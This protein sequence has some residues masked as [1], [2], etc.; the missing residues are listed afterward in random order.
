MPGDRRWR[1][2]RLPRSRASA[3]GAAL[4]AALL[5]AFSPACSLTG[6]GRRGEGDEGP[7]VAAAEPTARPFVDVTFQEYTYVDMPQRVVKIFVPAAAEVAR[8]WADVRGTQG[9]KYAYWIG[10]SLEGNPSLLH[11]LV[12]AEGRPLAVDGMQASGF[13]AAVEIPPTVTAPT[14][15]KI[16]HVRVD[17]AA[18]P[19]H[20]A[21][22]ARAP[23]LVVIC[24][25]GPAAGPLSERMVPLLHELLRGPARLLL[26]PKATHAGL[27]TLLA[28]W[29]LLFA[30]VMCFSFVFMV[31]CSYLHRRCYYYT[32]R[33]RRL[34]WLWVLGRR[35]AS[36]SGEAFGR[37]GPCCICLGACDRSG[38]ALVALLP[39]RHA[40][41]SECYRKWVHADSYP[42]SDLIC[43]LCRCRTQ[44]IGRLD[45]EPDAEAP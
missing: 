28:G 21:G 26:Y 19:L 31:L 43:P 9:V 30:T 32:R 11:M 6:Y 8:W 45:P 10:R 22:L 44:A 33:W 12:R 13:T 14:D 39:C 5:V 27:G 23:A 41:H 2:A 25:L 42:S 15:C 35:P 40:L 18:G 7:S 20:S 16:A 34:C 1:G 4:A 3:A 29:C 38:E 36:W 37:G 24:P 17:V